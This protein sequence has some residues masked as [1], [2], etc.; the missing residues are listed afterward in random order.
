MKN[1][2][3]SD[4]QS[5]AG[6]I[7]FVSSSIV[8]QLTRHVRFRCLIAVDY[9]QGWLF[10]PCRYYSINCNRAHIHQQL[11]TQTWDDSS[12]LD[13][14][15][16]TDENVVCPFHS[17]IWKVESNLEDPCSKYLSNK[18]RNASVCSQWRCTPTNLWM[19]NGKM[20][21]KDIK[22]WVSRCTKHF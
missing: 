17:A 7:K 18:S 13:K 2:K 8:P 9:E 4:S 14:W 11:L 16:G 15:Q 5:K 19:F 10:S 12:A 3:E 22:N 21:L 20:L 1:R 6:V